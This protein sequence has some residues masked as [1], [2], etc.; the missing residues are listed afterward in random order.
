VTSVYDFRAMTLGGKETSLS[1]F[2]GQVMLVVNTASKCGFTPQYEGLEKLYEAHKAQG[3]SVLGFPCNQFGKQEPGGEA[4]IGQFC[5]ANYGV[6]FPMFAKIEVNGRG[7]HPLY[8]YLK[9]AKR[10]VLGTSGIKWNFTKFLIDRA[11]NVVARYA[12]LTKPEQLE[13]AIAKLL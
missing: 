4:E 11:G 3:F 5:Q 2:K 13:G 10:G 12:P 7:A 9:H 6:S 1:D 8:D